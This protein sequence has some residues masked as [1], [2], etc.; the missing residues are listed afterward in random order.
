MNVRVPLLGKILAWFFLNLLVLAAVFYGVFHAQLR[1]GLDSLLA[2]RAGDRIR[3]VSELAVAELRDRPAGEWDGV[4]KNFGSA[5]KVAFYV[6]RNDGVQAAGPDVAL[7]ESAAARVVERRPGEGMGM[8]WGP[9]LGRGPR[10][11]PEASLAAPQPVFMV[12]GGDPKRYWTGV[13]LPLMDQSQARPCPLIL[14]LASDS[15][16]AGGLFFDATPWVAAGLGD[17]G[18]FGALLGAAGSERHAVH[19]GD[20]PRG[21]TDLRRP[22][23]R[24]RRRETP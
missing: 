23:R 24:P 10:H 4:L 1:L 6:F 15:L 16:A 18:L 11:G 5:Y 19:L 9:R 8:G 13:R 12:R 21:R 17:A 14:V 7:P 2:G 20:D 22:L 3:A